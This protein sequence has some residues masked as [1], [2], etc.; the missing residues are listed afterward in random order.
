MKSGNYFMALNY[1]S[2]GVVNFNFGTTYPVTFLNCDFSIRYVFV[3]LCRR[4]EPAL[5][6]WVGYPDR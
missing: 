2:N 3:F 1:L 6:G 5:L 4:L